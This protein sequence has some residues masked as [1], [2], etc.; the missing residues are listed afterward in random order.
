[1][2]INH[3]INPKV[4]G[5]VIGP[6]LIAFVTVV[7]RINEGTPIESHLKIPLNIHGEEVFTKPLTCV[8]SNLLKKT[9][10]NSM[11]KKKE[12]VKGKSEN[13]PHC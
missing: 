3:K 11:K 5:A 9:N 13:V 6:M 1:M 7:H 2:F 4:L 10:M 8:P 12:E